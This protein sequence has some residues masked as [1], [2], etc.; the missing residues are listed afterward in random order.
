MWLSCISC[1]SLTP[2]LEEEELGHCSAQ[3]ELLTGN[4][5]KTSI[6]SATAGT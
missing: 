5:E 3:L 2:T 4:Y 1:S 6:L